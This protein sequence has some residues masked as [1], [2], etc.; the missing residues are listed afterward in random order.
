VNEAKTA[1]R[2]QSGAGLSLR[3]LWE[4]KRPT[5]GGWCA[6]PTAFS[7]ELM[8]SAGFDWVCI[9]TQHG[10]IGYEQM[11][12]ML[13]ALDARDTPSLVRVPWNEPSAIMKALDAGADGVVVPM[14]GS[15]DEAAAAVGACRYP[16]LGYRS[17]GPAR[18]VLR[19]PRYS[20]EVA[21]RD[22][23]CVIMVETVE[24]VER[25]EEILDV[26]GI[27]CI[28][29][30]PADLSLSATQDVVTPGSKPAEARLMERVQSACSARGVVAGTACR[31]VE[32]L[33]HW[34]AAGFG[35]FQ[36]SSDLRLLSAA[37]A[38]IVRDARAGLEP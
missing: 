32:D 28:M 38:D 30:G 34:A 13:Q 6:I 31:R 19:D 4:T 22:V 23:V 1:E 29:I 37:A 20:P 8:A 33:H 18:P 21:N 15:A 35:M 2:E 25:I 27:D 36:L 10:L 26:P 5:I 17:W 16:P 24:G 3:A 14:I 12:S 9:D 7:A 11:T